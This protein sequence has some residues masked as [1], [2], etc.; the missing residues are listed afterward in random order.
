MRRSAR[1]IV[2]SLSLVS[3]L[4][5]FRALASEPTRDE[6]TTPLTAVSKRESFVFAS[7]PNGL[8]RASLETKRWERLKTPS[9]MPPNGNFAA[10]PGRSPVV[11]YVATRSKFNANNERPRPGSR[12]GLYVTKDNGLTWELVSE[13]DDFGATLLDPSGVLFAV[14]GDDGINEGDSVLRSTD[15]GKTWRNIT[16]T[17]SGQFMSL[18]PDPDHPG[19]IRIHAW[20]FREYTLVADDENYQWRTVRGRPQVAG[21]RPSND[22][23]SRNSSSTNRLYVYPATL[24]NY[25]RYD[26]GDQVSAQ[27]LEVVP[28][29]TRFEFARGT[30]VVVPVRVVFHF[31]PDTALAGPRNAAADGR[32]IPKPTPPVE[33][34]ADQ[35]N[36]T[37]F[38]GLRVESVGDQIEKYPAGRRV[39]TTSF[40]TTPDGKTVSSTH[41]PP[42]VKYRVVDLSPSSPYAREIDLGRLSD[43]SKPGEYRVQIIYDS[44]GHPEQEESVWDGDF[45][46]PVFTVV[47]REQPPAG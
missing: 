18:S 36:G 2:N 39:V 19:L 38:W 44:G 8:F 9:E 35:A 47:I 12:Y 46:S 28:E 37:D 31:D 7:T 11:I 15:L 25:F 13:R 42:A 45:T 41:Q 32:P 33:K 17:A 34:F 6:A 26:F 27:A 43:F 22:F 29:K 14:T 20:A 40:E 24:S 1:S 16:G 4:L 3:S 23:F 21:R 10:Q 5:G 30:R